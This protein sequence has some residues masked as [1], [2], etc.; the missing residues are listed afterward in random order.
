MT[1][2]FIA[3]IDGS[4][5]K[6]PLQI[7][8]GMSNGRLA[9]LQIKRF[10]EEKMY[11]GILS[12]DSS[13]TEFCRL[14]SEKVLAPLYQGL[15]TPP[16]ATSPELRP[17]ASAV[18]YSIMRKE[19]WMV[20]DC[21]AMADGTLY[22]NPKPYEETVA[23]K[24]AALIHGGKS[25]SEARHMI[26]TDLIEAMRKGQNRHYAV[27][28]GCPVYMPNVRIIPVCGN[29]AEVILASDGYP[30]LMPTLAESELA[31]SRQ[32]LNDPQNIT[33]FIATKGIKPGNKSFDDRAYIR[34]IV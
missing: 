20:G 7:A 16:E 13:A 31:L 25:P 14:I 28:D 33:S 21:Q 4:T 24:R 22:G 2:D 3:V 1:D 11:D 15:P 30:F 27:L 10:F 6:T 32:L 26:E 18:I 19:I 9:M 12:A 5:S 23:Q 29:N 17:T 34:F 8:P